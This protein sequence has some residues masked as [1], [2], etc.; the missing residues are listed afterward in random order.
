MLSI[1]CQL[2]EVNKLPCLKKVFGFSIYKS[3]LHKDDALVD[4]L[5][6]PMNFYFYRQLPCKDCIYRT[7]ERESPQE[8][9]PARENSSFGFIEA[10][11]QW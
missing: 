8:A 6:N 9:Q 10:V 2:F 4:V 7:D 3:H 11:H 5:N 1:K